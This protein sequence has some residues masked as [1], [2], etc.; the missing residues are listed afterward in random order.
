[1]SVSYL[2][3]FH[4]PTQYLPNVPY[5]LIKPNYLISAFVSVLFC[6]V[7]FYLHVLTHSV[8]WES[9][10]HISSCRNY[11]QLLR[12]HSHAIFTKISLTCLSVI[13]LGIVKA[14]C[15]VKQNLCFCPTLA[16]VSFFQLDH[17][18]REQGILNIYIPPYTLQMKKWI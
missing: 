4:Y 12:C 16:V 2:I 7:L 18:F 6:L 1:M 5:T 10:C 8:S 13:L 17:R 3:S 11:T 14:L 9:S 15:V